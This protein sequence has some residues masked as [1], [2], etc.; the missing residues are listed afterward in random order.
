MRI[1]IR[2]QN[3]LRAEAVLLAANRE[4]MRVAIASQ[5]DTIELHKVDARW[6]TEKEEEIEIETLISMEGTDV[7]QFC[8]AVF[9]RASV[10]GSGSILSHC[11]PRQAQI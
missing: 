9:P 6:F 10:A 8:A 7:S 3:G 5:R 1:T 11:C 4:R 2:Y